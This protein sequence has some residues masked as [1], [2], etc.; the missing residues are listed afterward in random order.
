MPQQ[1]RGK[2]RERINRNQPRA[3]HRRKSHDIHFTTGLISCIEH[4]FIEGK[5]LYSQEAHTGG[6]RDDNKEKDTF[7][8]N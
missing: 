7:I 6:S 8:T 5:F 4:A 2:K 3:P 1:G